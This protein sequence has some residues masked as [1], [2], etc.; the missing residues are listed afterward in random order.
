MADDSTHEVGGG[1]APIRVLIADD[2]EL[3][4]QGLR[5]SL[6]AAGGIEVAGEADNGERAVELA[7]ELAPDVVLMDID[8]PLLDGISATAIIRSKHPAT[9]VIALSMYDDMAHVARMFEAGARGYLLKLSAA[10]DVVR[11]VNAVV[12]DLTFLSPQL[13]SQ[14]L[15][16]FNELAAQPAAPDAPSLQALTPREQEVLRLVAEG[17]ASKV[18]ALELDISIKTVEAHRSAIMKK[19]GLSTVPELTKFAVR[20]GLTK[21]EG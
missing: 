14:V 8:M 6:N 13:T 3:V 5:A 17:T 2:H 21:L 7:T 16:R 20:S 9:R 4:R 18:I 1:S 19:L 11:A 12:G 10:D 15:S